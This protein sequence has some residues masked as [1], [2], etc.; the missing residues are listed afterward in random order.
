MKTSFE[1]ERILENIICSDCLKIEILKYFNVRKK[2]FG[3]YSKLMYR[4]NLH[5]IIDNINNDNLLSELK[6]LNK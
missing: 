5:Y 1:L 3:P 2:C 6:N 4:S